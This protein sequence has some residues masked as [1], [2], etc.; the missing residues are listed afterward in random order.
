MQ[1]CC[2]TLWNHL[3]VLNRVF[4][5]CLKW[6]DG[7]ESQESCSIQQNKSFS[8]LIEASKVFGQSRHYFLTPLKIQETCWRPTWSPHVAWWEC[9]NLWP[10]PL[11][12]QSTCSRLIEELSASAC[13]L[14]SWRTRSKCRH[15]RRSTLKTPS[16]FCS[17]NRSWEASVSSFRP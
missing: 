5:F 13:A 17:W 3:E 4:K 10:V 11:K 16:V 1:S 12:T 15:P 2:G 8:N 14:M 9:S 6:I 7:L